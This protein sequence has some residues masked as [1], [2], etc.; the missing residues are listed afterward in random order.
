MKPLIVALDVETEREALGLVKAT[1]KHADI[2]K[3]GPPL[4]LKYGQPILKKIRRMRKEKFAG[5]STSSGLLMLIGVVL[6]MLWANSP[7]REAYHALWESH[8]TIGA[9][10]FALDMSLHHWV[11]DGL[12]VLFFLV[13]GLEIRRELTVGDLRNPRHAA[14]PVAAA[15]GGMLFPALIYFAFTATTPERGGWGVPMGTDTA[16]ALGLLALLGHRVP[17]AL[18]VF[19]AA[20]AIADDVGSIIVI[21]FFYTA[22]ISMSSIAIAVVLLALAF[23]LNRAHVYRALPYTVIGLLLWLAV[24]SSGVHA[25]LAG[26]V[27]AFAIPT[28]GAPNAAALLAQTESILSSVE[29]P[30]FGG[31]T[32]S[33]YQAAV[34]ALEEMVE[35]LLSPAQRVARDLQ[36]WVAYL[37]LPVFH[38]KVVR[39]DVRDPPAVG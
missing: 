18:R 27:L 3:V 9:G 34:R 31:K 15:V 37:V 39:V 2:Y 11:N 33:S 38:V 5:L 29:T 4:I 25:T 35:R 14:L 19:V 6:A 23:A 13:V 21:A 28:R 36:P 7:W 20:A 24:L 26:V 1:R 32:E 12:I 8:L 30:A 17:L 10:R 22:S 16:F